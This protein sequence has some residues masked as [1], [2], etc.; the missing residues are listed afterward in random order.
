M[1]TPIR[2][3]MVGARDWSDTAAIDAVL[4]WTPPGSTVILAADPGLD[5]LAASRARERGL[6]VEVAGIPWNDH[7][8]WC[9]CGHAGIA[10]LPCA[11]ACSAY[12]QRLLAEL[13]PTHL[14]A[15]PTATSY[16]ALD[17]LTKARAAGVAVVCRVYTGH[18]ST[19][20][21]DRFDV[22]RQHGGEAG[23]PFAPSWDLLRGFKQ[24]EREIGIR[25]DADWRAY[26]GAY[27]AEM[28]RSYTT[29]GEAW[30]ALIQRP[31]L[32]ACCVCARADHQKCHR[33]V[34]AR[35]LLPKI[36]PAVYCG[37]LAP[38]REPQQLGLLG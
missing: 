28:R 12:N 32:V 29:H 33:T 5:A 20:D 10:E 6:H 27:T 14:A 35:D 22:T 3:W 2:L 24:V 18:V 25:T 36:G 31:R 16:R 26:A 1:K 21:P 34:L 30:Q 19:R 13:H 11:G 8:H 38:A 4:A 9:S 37:E 17:A 15:F 7:G 23:A